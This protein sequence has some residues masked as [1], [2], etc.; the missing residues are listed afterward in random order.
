MK[1]LMSLGVGVLAIGLLSSCAMPPY[2]ELHNNVGQ[3]LKAYIRELD[4]EGHFKEGPRREVTLKPGKYRR[5]WHFEMEPTLVLAK[6]EC[7]YVYTPPADPQGLY[8]RTTAEVEPDLS[9]H[10]LS[11]PS[12]DAEP[13]EFIDAFRPGFPMK[14]ESKLCR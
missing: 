12:R 8:N 10:L 5:F 7:A 9:I 1:I 4:R 6:G 11:I 13:G 2:I 3:P 14:P